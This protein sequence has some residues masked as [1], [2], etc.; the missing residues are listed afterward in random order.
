VEGTGLNVRGEKVA[1]PGAYRNL[2]SGTLELR[3]KTEKESPV[4]PVAH[5]PLPSC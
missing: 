1:R 4:G 2:P 3:K 5:C